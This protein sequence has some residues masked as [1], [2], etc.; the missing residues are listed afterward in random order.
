[1]GFFI[2]TAVAMSQLIMVNYMNLFL[3]FNFVEGDITSQT[4]IY[5][6]VQ[7]DSSIIF[8]VKIIEENGCAMSLREYCKILEEYLHRRCQV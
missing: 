3:V 7:N 1:M 8:V 4:K 5:Q 6:V 2:N